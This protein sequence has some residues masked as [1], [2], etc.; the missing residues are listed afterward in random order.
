MVINR[1]LLLSVMDDVRRIQGYRGQKPSKTLTPGST[2][3]DRP[4]PFRVDVLNL[5]I[6]T[7]RPLGMG[8]R[9]TRTCMVAVQKTVD[10]IGMRSDRIG[11][12]KSVDWFLEG[13]EP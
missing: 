10:E 11:R 12:W 7:G 3:N 5:S 4:A 2:T 6:C 13:G 1:T 8:I 9:E